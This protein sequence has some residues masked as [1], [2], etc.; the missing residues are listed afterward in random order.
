[1]RHFFFLSFAS[2]ALILCFSTF[3][4][5]ENTDPLVI[6]R[7]VAVVNSEAITLSELDERWSQLRG[8]PGAPTTREALLARMIELKLQRQRAITLKVAAQPEEIEDALTGILT[9]NNI[10]SM[11]DLEKLLAK[12]GRSLAQF[13]KEIGTQIS[14]MRVMQAEVTSKIHLSEA[15]L[16]SYYDA[17][18]SEFVT[19]GI[20][21]LRQIHLALD[22][23]AED[24]TGARTMA[25]LRQ[26]VNDRAD[27]MAA[28]KGLSGQPGITV[29][30]AGEFARD[31]LLPELS[32]ALFNLPKGAV[33]QPITLPNG[34]AIF[35]VDTITGGEVPPFDRVIPLIRERANSIAAR[36]VMV[37]WLNDLKANA[38]IEMRDL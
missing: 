1:M 34:T 16:H 27:F 3:S 12:D 22:N 30:A 19:N 32:D 6:D 28:E 17:H 20:I 33:S 35:L 5:A 26:R 4:P 8:T 11:T 13:R 37:H 2:L 10:P 14:L 36:R 9:D 29:G 18:R 21:H 23:T 38:Y 31:E 7:V 15:D 25:K 24:S